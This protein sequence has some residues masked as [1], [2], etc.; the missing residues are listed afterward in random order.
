MY[1]FA[2]SAL[3][4]ELAA[5]R[6]GAFDPTTWWME[7]FPVFLILPVVWYFGSKGKLSPLLQVLIVIHAGLLCMGAHYTYERVP[8]GEWVR[9]LGIGTRNNYDKLGHFAQGF[10]PAIAMREI[11]MRIGFWRERKVL[12]SF[13]VV[14]VCGGVSAI[15]EIIEMLAALSMGQGADAFLGTQGYVWDTQTDMAS[16]LIGALCALFLFEKLQRKQLLTHSTGSG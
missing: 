13:V 15:Y 16:A 5:S 11:F 1:V 7:V 14:L 9:H 10:I 4:L 12:L 3:I 6:I 8:L 2:L